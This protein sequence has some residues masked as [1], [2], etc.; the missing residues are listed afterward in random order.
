MAFHVGKINV[1]LRDKGQLIKGMSLG[2]RLLAPEPEVPCR[3]VHRCLWR[4]VS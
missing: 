1:K 4:G 3:V 2:Y